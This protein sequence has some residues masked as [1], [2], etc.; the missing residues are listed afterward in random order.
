[1][2]KGLRWLAAATAEFRA[3]L[4]KSGEACAGIYRRRRVILALRTAR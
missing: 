4:G 2:S 3:A 1:M